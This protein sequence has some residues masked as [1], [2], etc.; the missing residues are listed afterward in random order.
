M[1]ALEHHENIEKAGHHHSS[2]E[3]AVLIA[4]LAALLAICEMGGKSAQ[5]LSLASNIEASNL[6]AFFQAKTVRMT[7]VRTAAEAYEALGNEGV[8]PERQAAVQKQ[9]GKWRE[10]QT[11]YDDEPETNEGRKQLAAR[12]KAAEAT[13]D[14]AL[15]AYHNF[16]FGS[17]AF[18]LAIV[19]ASA[20][21][22][23]GV[24]L[25]A[26]TAGALGAIGAV[27]CLLGWFAPT[28]VHF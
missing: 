9:I 17:A 6:W 10:A 3:I 12:A 2:K 24:V 22:V 13:R 8:P 18:Q 11:R 5:H 23:T 21:L 20:S 28:L 26:W 15:A 25:L 4:A 19:L 1:E 7:T 14:R 27:L 16:E